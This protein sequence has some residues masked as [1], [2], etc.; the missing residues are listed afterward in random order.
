MR[1]RRAVAAGGARALG[2]LPHRLLT[3]SVSAG[4]ARA[5]L[6]AGA[7]DGRPGGEERGV[8]GGRPRAS[9]QPGRD[10]YR[11]T[12]NAGSVVVDIFDEIGYWGVTAADFQRELAAVTA[13]D[14]TVNLNSPGGEIFEGI[15]IY[16]ALRS[17][18]ANITIRVAGLAASI[19]SVIAQAGDRVVMQPHS[20]MMI[21]DGSGLAIGNAQDM[22]DM[23]DLLDRQSNNIAAVYAERAGGIVEEW[24]ARML[25]ETW[26]SADEAVA[27]GLADEVDAPARQAE[28]EPKLQPAA[29]WD[30]SVFRHAGREH[31]P[32]PVL[33]TAPTVEAPAAE[34]PVLEE[35]PPAAEPTAEVEPVVEP[36]T[37]EPEPVP[38]PWAGLT[39]QLLTTPSWDDVTARLR[40]ASK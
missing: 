5:A 16:N 14:I 39:A 27:A 21:H 32:A 26:Y 40:E 18:P 4:A 30:L 29:N 38:D 19:A 20:Q 13:A 35:Q 8:R 31:A 36:N 15:A 34:T 22:R 12:N 11:I 6:S 28:P 23:A 7:G 3:N 37:P 25:A 9:L 17:H 2:P 33:N 10:W 1:L 24:R